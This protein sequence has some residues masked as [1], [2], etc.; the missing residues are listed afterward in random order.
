MLN[1]RIF[2]QLSLAGL[3]ST[4]V[5]D[6]FAGQKKPAAKGVPKP[7]STTVKHRPLGLQLYTL[8][9]NIDKNLPSILNAVSKIGYKEVELFGPLYDLPAAEL[10]KM[11][12]D[13]GLTAPS[14]HFGYETLEEKLDYAEELGLKYVICP[15]LPHD[16]WNLDGFREASS[17]LNVWGADLRHR[18]IRFGYHNHN[19]EF[20]PLDDTTGFDIIAANTDPKLVCF[21]LDCYWLAQ[22]G[23]D[24]AATITKYADRVRLLHLKDLKPGFPTSLNLEED[25][26]HFTEVGAGKLDWK[27]ILGAASSVG[28]EH[29]FV[30]RDSGDLPA[31][32]S[33]RISFNNLQK[34]L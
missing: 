27:S 3:A 24:P 1:R 26:K 28:V 15:M 19:Y 22:A 32:E 33:S 20:K 9:D 21:E 11:L 14:G 2:L 29:Q 7:T 8:R 25:A 5:P 10:R 17:Q 18:G 12:A 13:N 16:M 4:A 23:L 30:E 31:L 6:A 34:F